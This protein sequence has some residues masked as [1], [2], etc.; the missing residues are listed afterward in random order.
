[1]NQNKK[2]RKPKPLFYF[3]CTCILALITFIVWGLSKLPITSKQNK[4]QIQINVETDNPP[5]AVNNIPVFAIVT[6]EQLEDQSIQKIVTPTSMISMSYEPKSMSAITIPTTK[7]KI[8]LRKEANIALEKMYRALKK[9]GLELFVS[10]GYRSF[11]DQEIKFQQFVSQFGEAKGMKLCPA[12]GHA[13]NQ[14][15]LA[16]E[17]T[18]IQNNPYRQNFDETDTGKWLIQH[19]HEFGFIQRYPRNKSRYTYYEDMPWV[20]R[21]VGEELSQKMFEVGQ[22]CTIEEYYGLY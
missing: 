3:L 13:E 22:D 15:G 20:F 6:E 17:V 4:Q 16:I 1:M 11:E 8:L 18:D 10:D 9:D 12:P 19:A 2:F 14:T 7:S 5:I 21:Y